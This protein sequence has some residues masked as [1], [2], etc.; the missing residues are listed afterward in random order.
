MNPD[1]IKPEELRARSDS[2]E[3]IAGFSLRDFA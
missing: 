2:Y 3:R 1:F